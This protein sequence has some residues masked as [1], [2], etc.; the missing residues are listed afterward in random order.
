MSPT[1]IRYKTWSNLVLGFALTL[2]FFWMMAPFVVAFLIGA[3]VSIICKPLNQWARRT[4]SR[5]MAALTVTLGITLGVL[6]PLGATLFWVSHHLLSM[7]TQL[8]IPTDETSIKMM[9][10]QGSVHQ[11]IARL[12]EF[13]SLDKG[14]LRNQAIEVAQNVAQVLSKLIA[15]FLGAMPSFLLGLFVVIISVFF[16]LKD[17][18]RFVKFLEDLSPIQSSRS[19]ELY[20]TFETSCRGVVLGLFGSAMVQGILMFV[21]SAITGIPNP[22]LVGMITVV[23]GMM[24]IVGSAPVWITATIYLYFADSMVMGTVMLVGGI[25]IS[26]SDNV[27]RPL[28]MKGHSEMHPLLALVSVFG[29]INLFGATGIFLGPIIA[30]VFVSFLNIVAQEIRREKSIV[31]PAASLEPSS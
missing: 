30:A 7:I 15:N 29:A 16:L 6:A 5:G 3:V 31:S 21:F 2:L 11:F 26:V 1:H 10:R 18:D 8:K 27:V 12:S 13:L 19:L 17:G 25:L 20:R 9:V 24:P 14:W 4:M 22:F 28:I 23:M